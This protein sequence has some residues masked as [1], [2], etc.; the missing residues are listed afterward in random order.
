MSTNTCVCC[1][2]FRRGFAPRRPDRPQVCEVCR[3][4]FDTLVYDLWLLH[5]RLVNPDP[6]E[7]DQRRYARRD[8]QGKRTGEHRWADPLAPIGG[9]GTIPGKT[10]QPHVS[11]TPGRSTPANLDQVDL[12]SP[13]RVPNPTAAGRR[14]PWDQIGHLSV[15]TRLYEIVR[16]WRDTLW[17][18]QHLPVPTMDELVAWMR[19]GA[20][21]G[22]A[23]DRTDHACTRHPGIGDTAAELHD[24]RRI[25]RAQ[26]GDT[27]PQP[28]RWIGVTCP[29]CNEVSQIQ[30]TAG[31]E[32][33]E[34]AE[35]GRMYTGDQMTEFVT[36]QAAATRAVATA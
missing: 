3:L 2:T 24:L 31:D 23:G 16:D 15:A 4:R 29:T 27:E 9:A 13:A 35:C 36:K 6:A 14:D 25:L 11:G 33:A 19:A 20:T 12:T 22:Y 28:R 7:V 34:C 1:P 18:D 26:L 8:Q 21:D 10:N 5:D 32:Y 30:Q 17:P